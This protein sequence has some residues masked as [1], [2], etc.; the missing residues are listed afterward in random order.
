MGTDLRDEWRGCWRRKGILQKSC[1]NKRFR[2]MVTQAATW[3]RLNYNA[4]LGAAKTPPNS[5]FTEMLLQWCGQLD[6]E[7]E[8]PSIS[9]NSRNNIVPYRGI[10]GVL[11]HVGTY[12][13]CALSGTRILYY[14]CY[15]GAEMF[16]GCLR[17]LLGRMWETWSDKLVCHS[18]IPIVILNLQKRSPLRRF[19]V[20]FQHSNSFK[21]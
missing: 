2:N 21:L 14:G 8:Y 1:V 12:S 17:L 9:A 10:K 6:P 19:N 15:R 20:K 13:P 3:A 5:I 16:E 18:L 7:R 11:Q 4:A